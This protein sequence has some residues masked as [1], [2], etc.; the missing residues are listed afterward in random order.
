MLES[1]ALQL[2]KYALSEDVGT[3]DITSLNSIKSGVHARAAIV[4]KEPGV[5]AG[6]DVARITFREADATLRF[7]PMVR[8]RRAE[9][10]ARS[11]P[12]HPPGGPVARGRSRVP[13]SAQGG[14]APGGGSGAARQPLGRGGA[15]CGGR[16]RP[17][18]PG[19]SA[20]QPAHGPG[21]AAVAGDR[22]L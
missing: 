12:A 9:R 8:G 10:G 7:R 2:V 17:L 4:V 11:H 15:A 19:S 5:I 13:R 3:G 6:L 20:G 16:D 1:V 14:V 21:C 18:V 22:S